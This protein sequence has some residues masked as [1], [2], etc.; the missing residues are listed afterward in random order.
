MENGDSCIIIQQAE[1][2]C[3]IARP[4]DFDTGNSLNGPRIKQSFQLH[5]I[6]QILLMRELSTEQIP[7]I[8]AVLPS[9]RSLRG[10][11]YVSK[12]SDGSHK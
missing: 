5:M 6:S 8:L 10:I 11:D 1:V 4:S 7:E 9:K 2:I 3:Q 12:S